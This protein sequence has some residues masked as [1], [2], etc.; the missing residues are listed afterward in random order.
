MHSGFP[1]KFS[2]LLLH[3]ELYCKSRKDKDLTG[4][5]AKQTSSACR[6]QPRSAAVLGEARLATPAIKGEDFQI[7]SL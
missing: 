3:G 7:Y 2:C 1:N 5:A 6:V 4:G